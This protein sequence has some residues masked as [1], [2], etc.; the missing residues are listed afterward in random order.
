MVPTKIHEVKFIAVAGGIEAAVAR[1]TG[2]LMRGIQDWLGNALWKSH[3]IHGPTRPPKKNQLSAEYSPLDPKILLGPIKPHLTDAS[4]KTR[5]L[6]QVQGLFE[7]RRLSWHMFSVLV[8]S[9]HATQRLIVPAIN[10][11]N[12]LKQ[13]NSSWDLDI[14]EDL[15]AGSK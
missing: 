12:E 14:Q 2:R 1:S 11:A 5:S 3:N 8:R 13:R 10:G 6:G 15:L 7:G 9:N 4:K